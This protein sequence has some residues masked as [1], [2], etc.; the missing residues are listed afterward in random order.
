MQPETLTA[1]WNALRNAALGRGVAPLVDAA[2]AAE[3]GQRYEG[4]RAWLADVTRQYG[5]AAYVQVELVG[6]QRWIDEYRELARRVAAVRGAAYRP[7]ADVLAPSFVEQIA[8]TGR[9]LGGFV[10][11]TG[12]AV[13][14]GFVVRAW[15]GNGR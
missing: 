15:R 1:A 13:G 7:D 9:L 5:P 4:Y 8:R 3:V 10:V 11:A 2:L 14:L 6:G 12:V